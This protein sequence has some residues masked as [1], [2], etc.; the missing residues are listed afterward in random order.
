MNQVDSASIL[1]TFKRRIFRDLLIKRVDNLKASKALRE[2]IIDDLGALG[3]VNIVD[4][5]LRQG[6][7]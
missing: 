5:Y 2:K 4:Y 6:Y 1:Y 3:T 7:I